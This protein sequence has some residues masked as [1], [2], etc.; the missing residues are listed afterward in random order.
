MTAFIHRVITM[1]FE[2]LG[3]YIFT[4]E[5]ETSW[6]C[7]TDTLLHGPSPFALDRISSADANT[8]YKAIFTWIFSG[9]LTSSP[10]VFTTF[11]TAKRYDQKADP[12]HYATRTVLGFTSTLTSTW[13][14]CHLW[15]TFTC[16]LTW[17]PTSYSASWVMLS[18][19]PQTSR[20]VFAIT[21][22]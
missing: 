2:I 14:S 19:A 1:H 22:G 13:T 4:Q 10:F 8:P 12:W 21:S 20:E 9:D 5:R 16:I 18:Q 7:A 6:T 17:H 15:M 3:Y 11:I